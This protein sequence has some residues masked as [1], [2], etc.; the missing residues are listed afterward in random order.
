MSSIQ[1]S[2][3]TYTV[4][5]QSLHKGIPGNMSFKIRNK[6]INIEHIF[7]KYSYS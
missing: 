1:Y 2:N 7:I 5:V 6:Q 4:T 3:A